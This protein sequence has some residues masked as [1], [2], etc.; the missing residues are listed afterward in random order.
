MLR[1]LSIRDFVI[2]DQLEI[3][4]E[5]GFT[6]FSGETGAGKSILIDAVALILGARADSS[7][8]R[9]GS[10]KAEIC[11]EFTLEDR[12]QGWLQ[13]QDMGSEQGILLRRVIDGAGRSRAW[14]NGVPATLTQ[15]RELGQ[16]LVEIHGQSEHQ[17]LLEAAQQRALLD[18]QAGLTSLAAQV[19]QSF[20]VWQAIVEQ[21]AALERDAKSVIAER[22]R[23]E[24]QVAELER[25]ALQPGE[26]QDLLVEHQRLAHAASLI[27]G[28]A[29]ALQELSEADGSLIERVDGLIHRL[30][31]LAQLDSTLVAVT[32]VLEPA[33]IQIQE[34]IRGLND[35]ASRL[36][37][38]PERLA[39]LEARIEATHSTSRKFRVSPDELPSEL[40]R[41][42]DQLET[43]ADASNLEELRAREQAAHTAYMEG[44][45]ALSE[46]RATG[47]RTMEQAITKAMQ[48]L[49]MVGGRFEIIRSTREPSA[50]GLEDIE[51][52]VAG[53]PNATPRPLAKVASGGE[54]AR[55]SLA[56]SVVASNATQVPSL[57]F[58]EV[59]SGIGGAV[60][61]V[62]G[63]LLRELGRA[64][65]VLCVTHLP[66]V[67]AQGDEHFA[68]NKD[69]ARN[70]TVS[71]ITHLD[72]PG[73]IDELARML[74]GMEI[75]ST[76]RKHAREL[77]ASVG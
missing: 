20:R 1:N 35:Y 51:Y 34:A 8:V 14:I 75:T 73:R 10:S 62:V 11:A 76:T 39:T 12:A 3:E 33:R 28:S 48:S 44:A 38:E 50:H 37:L 72:A 70:Q 5:G 69:M 29:Q 43:L 2:V 58:D 64:R 25:L 40:S 71:R 74:G 63:R 27:E 47:A 54:L 4:F 45:R 60:A 77:L 9:E 31:H 59:D 56:I 30:Q 15:L 41:L 16:L 46:G 7:V 49:S 55:I 22:E 42:S 68:V 24:W 61:E 67:A 66:Q 52:R 26:W 19:A 18:A 53:H 21:R 65:Q 36:E 32:E 6:V 57:I 17:S 23:L 13:K